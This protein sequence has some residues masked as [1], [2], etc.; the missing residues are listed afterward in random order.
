M[1]FLASTASI[2]ATLQHARQ[3]QQNLAASQQQAAAATA[4][5]G[6]NVRALTTTSVPDHS[7]LTTSVPQ[8]NIRPQSSALKFS[9]RVISRIFSR[10]KLYINFLDRKSI[11]RGFYKRTVRAPNS[12]TTYSA[13]G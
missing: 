3:Q 10:K 11:T 7:N 8:Q 6:P 4:A 9:S 1:E 13:I 5:N 2:L 12:A